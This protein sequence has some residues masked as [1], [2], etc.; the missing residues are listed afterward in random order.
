MKL[1]PL[2]PL[3]AAQADEIDLNRPVTEEQAE[4]VHQAMNQYAVLVFRGQDLDDDQHMAFALALGDTETSRATVDV[5]DHR[6]KHQRMNDISNIGTDGRLLARDSRRR[7]FNLGNRLWHTD[8]SF[9]PTPAK[10]SLL[11]AHQVP[12]SGGDTEFADMRAAWDG[13]DED[14]RN[15][16]SGLVARHSLLYSRARLGW[17]GFTEEEKAGFEPVPQ[18]LVR[19]HPG[20]GRLSLYLASHIGEIDGWPVA[21]AMIFISDLV[22]HAT[23][24][25]YVYRHKWQ[26]GDLVIWDNRCT[27]H[28]ATAFDDV[29]QPRDVRRVTLRDSAPTLDQPL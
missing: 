28:R 1:T 17:H 29:H 21:E 2:H 3:F 12:E 22:E 11:Y 14:M 5:S 9:K 20:S 6:L 23:R 24:P 18:R 4:Q 25:E 8:S 13:L 16:A 27:M 15:R 19:R 26:Q 10:Y 7:M